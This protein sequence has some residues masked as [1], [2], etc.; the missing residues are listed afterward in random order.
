MRST[1]TLMPRLLAVPNWYDDARVYPSKH[2]TNAV[3]NPVSSVVVK[4]R[5]ALVLALVLVLALPL[6]L[7]L[8]STAL[9]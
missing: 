3:V 9:V 5:W 2:P 7:A 8:A 1:P 6:A 4:S